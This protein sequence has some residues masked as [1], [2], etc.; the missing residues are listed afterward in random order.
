MSKLLRAPEKLSETSDIGW[1]K[2]DFSNPI[3]AGSEKKS[4]FSRRA[5]ISGPTCL[6]DISLQL[7][8][9]IMKHRA[10]NMPV[11]M[12]IAGSDSGAGAGIQ[13]DLLTFAALDVFGTT[14]ITSLTAQNPK[15]VS[16]V[17]AA[18]PEFVSAQLKQLFGYFDI[19]ALKTGMLYDAGIIKVVCDFIR[20]HRGIKS[21]VDPV[22]VAT[23]GAMLLKDDAVEIVRGELLPLASIVT[24][25]LDEASVLVGSKITSIEEMRAAAEKIA[26]W[27][28]NAV[29]VKGGHLNDSETVTDILRTKD[30]L[31]LEFA[32]KRIPGINTHGSGCTLSAA[33]AAYLAKGETVE[34]AVAAGRRYL[35]AGMRNPIRVSRESFI[36]HIH[37]SETREV[38][39][40]E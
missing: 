17:L 38:D 5:T 20:R 35:L 32:D 13:A 15:G 39:D 14:A 40:T 2:N 27:T 21:V 31:T 36:A 8:P 26:S 16:A 33:I 4:R 23:S 19:R 29:L 12:T 37:P 18:T 22:M 7:L 28:K 1:M 6:R 30:G 9:S 10:Q 3:G 11:A 25:N 34:E 24:P